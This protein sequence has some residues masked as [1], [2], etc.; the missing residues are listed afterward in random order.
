MKVTEGK[1]S[2]SGIKV[3]NENKG[4]ISASYLYMYGCGVILRLSIKNKGVKNEPAEVI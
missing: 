2:I 3:R 4:S 1:G